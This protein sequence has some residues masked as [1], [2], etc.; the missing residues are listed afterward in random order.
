VFRR[1]KNRENTD[2]QRSIVIVDCCGSALRG[3]YNDYLH[4]YH[5]EKCSSQCVVLHV[6]EGLRLMFNDRKH[7]FDTSEFLVDKNT[8]SSDCD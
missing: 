3:H 2:N 5:D 6:M 1:V 7:R 4:N 8:P